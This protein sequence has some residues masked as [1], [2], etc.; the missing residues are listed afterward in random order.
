MILRIDSENPDKR[1]IDKVVDCLRNG[2][3]Y[4]II[5]ENYKHISDI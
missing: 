3:A 1:R 4:Y 5:T 2:G